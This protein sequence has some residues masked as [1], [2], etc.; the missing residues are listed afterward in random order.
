MNRAKPLKTKEN[1]L[2]VG[3]VKAPHALKGEIFVLLFAKQ[4]DWLSK[5]EVCLLNDQ[6]FEVQKAKVNKDGIIL[7]L[8]GIDDR[9]ASE[10]LIGQDFF[11][12]DALLSAKA[13]EMIYLKQI[14]GFHLFDNHYGDLGPILSFG[15]NMAQDLLVVEYQGEEVSVP[16]VEAFIDRIDWPDRRILLQL[17]EG[18][19][20]A[21]MKN[22]P[23]VS[24]LHG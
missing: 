2:H 15:S 23:Q 16:F 18:L 14:E 20:E 5:L 12:P 3:K 11:I 7:K 13:G 4:S 21:Q 9:N 10:A 8:A 17:P 24:G 1:Y 22:S 19:L 6:Q